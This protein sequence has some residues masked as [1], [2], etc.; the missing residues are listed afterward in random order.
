M[1]Q[2]FS[3]G[4]NSPRLSITHKCS[5]SLLSPVGSDTSIVLKDKRKS[6]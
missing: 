6:E 4:Q 2:V 3:E 1:E 5:A